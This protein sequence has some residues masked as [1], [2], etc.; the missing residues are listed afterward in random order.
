VEGA[1]RGQIQEI[2]HR[3]GDAAQRLILTGTEA[4]HGFEQ[5]LRVR[6]LRE[7]EERFCSGD[8][9]NLAGVHHEH[10]PRHFGHHPQIVSD[11][12]W[13]N[14][15]PLAARVTLQGCGPGF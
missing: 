9:H 1:A 14:P 11:E 2:R 13:H 12:L 8:F 4:Q 6:V 7:P 10:A 15:P 5:A 3:S